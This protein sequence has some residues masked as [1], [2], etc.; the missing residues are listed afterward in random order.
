M[1]QKWSISQ[2]SLV[3]GVIGAL[4]GGIEAGLVFALKVP[5]HLSMD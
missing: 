3:V 4:F 5:L 2:C 1:M